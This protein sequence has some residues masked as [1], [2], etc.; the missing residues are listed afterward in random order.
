MLIWNMYVHRSVYLFTMVGP[1]DVGLQPDGCARPQGHPCAVNESRNV[2]THCAI[3][4]QLVSTF[5]V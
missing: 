3:Q 2:Y 1:I 5:F 4:I